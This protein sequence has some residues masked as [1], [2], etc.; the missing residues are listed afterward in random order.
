MAS[1]ACAWGDQWACRPDMVVLSKGYAS[2]YA[3]LGAVAASARVADAV[4][5]AGGMRVVVEFRGSAH[6]SDELRKVRTRLG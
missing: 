5:D 6:Y 2:G 1:T 3:P 4:L